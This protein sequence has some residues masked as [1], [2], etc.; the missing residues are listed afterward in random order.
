MDELVARIAATI[1]GQVESADIAE[2]RRKLPEKMTTYDY[3]LRGLEYH[4]LGGVTTENSREAVKWFERAIESDPNYGL[5]YAWWTCAASRLPGFDTDK[6]LKYVKKAIELDENNAEAHRIM[7]S[8]QM[9]LGDF[10][11]AEHHHRRAMALN[12]SSA[13]VRA[14]SAAFYTFNHQ[15]ERSLELLAEADALDPF[16]PVWCLEERG[17]ALFNLGKYN[18]AISA[19]NSLAFQTFRSRSYAA[20]CALALGDQQRAR[21]AV[22][23]AI[24]ISP[25]L[26]VS[27]LLKSEPYRYPVDADRLRKLLIEA[28]LPE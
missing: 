1:V 26:T 14:R 22:A 6:G 11:A 23:E 2:A 3:L 28:G 15:P 19:L 17:V 16:L 12:P 9:W 18:E 24:S 13:Y 10:E 25:G 21:N 27:K 4:R 20:A 7:G 8:Y 5:P